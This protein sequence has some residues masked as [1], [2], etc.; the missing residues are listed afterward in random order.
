MSIAKNKSFLLR[1]I[2]IE[3]L[4]WFVGFNS[5]ELKFIINLLFNFQSSFAFHHSAIF[6]YLIRFSLFSLTKF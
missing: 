3:Y 1:L 2:I 6:N 5:C 4:A